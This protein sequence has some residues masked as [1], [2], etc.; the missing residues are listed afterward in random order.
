MIPLNYLIDGA[1][2]Y[3]TSIEVSPMN[4]I[5]LTISNYFFDRAL[6]YATSFEI[7]PW[8]NIKLIISKLPTFVPYHEGLTFSP[9]FGHNCNNSAYRI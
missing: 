9:N 1:L 5:K 3:A 8:N 6:S 2:S 7:S 4:I